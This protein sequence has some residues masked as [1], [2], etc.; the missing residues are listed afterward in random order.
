MLSETLI[1]EMSSDS[2]SE[3]GGNLE[4]YTRCFHIAEKQRN[5]KIGHFC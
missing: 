4:S 1:F 3:T 2:Y 5:A